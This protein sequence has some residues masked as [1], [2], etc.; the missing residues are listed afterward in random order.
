MSDRIQEMFDGQRRLID[1]FYP[2]EV[3]TLGIDPHLPVDLHTHRGQARVKECA[4]RISEEVVEL[5]HADAAGEKLE[6]TADVLCFLLELFHV[7]GVAPAQ[8]APY[9][10]S[11]YHDSLECCMNR[12]MEANRQVEAGRLQWHDFIAEVWSWMHQLKA[13]P[14]KLTPNPTDVEGFKSHARWVF[15]IF[16][17]VCESEDLFEDELYEAYFDK[18]KINLE[19]IAKSNDAIH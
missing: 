10:G 1:K 13:K 16:L 4:G 2:I 7:I 17:R 9:C 12:A 8:F 5:L 15:F 14:W 3:Q 11:D 18:H 6:E 19:R